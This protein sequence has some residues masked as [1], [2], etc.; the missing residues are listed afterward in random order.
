MNKINYY[1]T[2]NQRRQ[3]EVRY[4]SKW[5]GSEEDDYSRPIINPCP[6]GDAHKR[7]LV[8]LTNKL[9]ENAKRNTNN[10]RYA[11]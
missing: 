7:L 11:N 8:E 6:E 5:D 10:K 4:F 3:R 2:P 9:K 1:N